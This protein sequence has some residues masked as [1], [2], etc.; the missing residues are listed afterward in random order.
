[1]SEA[2]A[3]FFAHPFWVWLAFAAV[4]LVAELHSGSGWLLWPAACAGLVALLT[5]FVPI[6]T[7]VAVLIFAL[8]TVVATFISRRLMKPSAH[9]SDINEPSL[10]VVGHHGMVVSAF[11]NGAGRVFVDGKEWAAEAEEG[12]APLPQQRVEVTAVKG[13]TLRVKTA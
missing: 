12:S 9:R 5:A 7:P 6:D 10:R 4:L 13:A 3:F 8:T 11:V 1:M 2:T